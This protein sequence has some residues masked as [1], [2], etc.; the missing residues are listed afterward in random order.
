MTLLNFPPTNGQPTDGSYTYTAN[1]VVYAWDGE[2]WTANSDQ[3]LDGN[4]VNKDGDT[5]T[6]DLT[7][8][9]LISEGDVQT[10]SLN[11]GPLS[12]FRNQIINGDF[13]VW[14]RGTSNTAQPDA[15]YF[16][17]DRWRMSGQTTLDRRTNGP[18]GFAYVG[19]VRRASGARQLQ[20]GIEV[21]EAANSYPDGAVY[22]LSYWCDQTID[23]VNARFAS[24]M[25]AAAIGTITT[26][27]AIAGETSNGFTHYSHR[28][29][30]GAHDNSPGVLFFLF[31]HS[32]DYQITGCQLE[33]GPVATPFEYRPYGTE[34]ALCQ[35]YFFRASDK[36][37]YWRGDIQN[38]KSYGLS[39]QFPVEMREPP[40]ISRITA[41]NINQM[42]NATQVGS[43]STQS[44]LLTAT[45]TATGSNGSISIGFDA[46]AEL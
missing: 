45:A 29:T 6:G 15:G 33:P 3:G 46:D 13:R 12:G 17:A 31:Q 41:S 38:T 26:D 39:G 4:Y 11:G 30:I 21:E 25:G 24:G 28:V 10:T 7:V 1:G 20:Y 35:R 32:A 9:N 27:A 19:R 22:T 2:K 43:A 18:A 34:L 42:G 36:Y 8:P 40:Q 16:S 44:V 37:L 5:M 23:T 14:Q